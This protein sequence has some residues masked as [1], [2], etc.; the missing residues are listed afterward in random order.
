MKVARAAFPNNDNLLKM[1]LQSFLDKEDYDG[2]LANLE[3]A[4]VSDPKNA[5]YLYNAGFIYHQKKKDL[6]KGREYYVLRWKPMRV[7]WMRST[8]WA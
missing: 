6:I 8:C 7:T 5:L 2:A 1:E 3:E 4:L